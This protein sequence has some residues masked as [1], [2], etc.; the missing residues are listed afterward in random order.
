MKIDTNQ[1]IKQIVLKD[2]GNM[3]RN[4]FSQVRW[5]SLLKKASSNRVLYVFV[6]NLYKS[7]FSLNPK[8]K[9][10]LQ[11]IIEVGNQK[12]KAF[13]DTIE[14][15]KKNLGFQ[16]IPYL[17]VKTFK[18]IDY[19]TFDVDVLVP[20]ESFDAAQK[21]LADNGCQI[22][23]HPRKQGFHQRN[24][25]KEG[26]LNIDLHRKFYWQGFEHID[27]DFVWKNARTR[28][29]NGIECPCPSLE[30]DFLLHN[31]QLVYERYYITLLDFLA[32]KFARK[33]ANFDME[34]VVTQVEKYKWAKS[35]KN[36]L[37][38]LNTIDT[39]LY[40]K[41]SNAIEMPFLYP[42]IQVWQQFF[43]ITQGQ[44][45]IP[46]YDFLYYHFAFGRYYLSK[47]ARFPYYQHWFD[48][49]LLT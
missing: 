35:F 38:H 20:Y 42:Y 17:V 11:K 6:Q 30:A 39:A 36:L 31:K 41:G 24:C 10:D 4:I 14:F 7:D 16:N 23:P 33:S 47:K 21:V 25:V 3:D 5:S 19:V 15:L 45:N 43:E 34:S 32:V 48:F 40:N 44:K 29:I 28:I 37:A 49:A 46:V 12:T 9:E 27:L 2:F 22:C 26:L 18:Y 13:R 1:I 8:Q